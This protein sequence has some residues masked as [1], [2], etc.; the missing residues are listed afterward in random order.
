MLEIRDEN[1]LSG[2]IPPS[3]CAK[4]FNVKWLSGTS[5]GSFYIGDSQVEKE[6]IAK[7]ITGEHK[8]KIDMPSFREYAHKLKQI[9][10]KFKNMFYGPVNIIDKNLSYFNDL[11]ENEQYIII[12]YTP[13]ERYLKT[14]TG[15]HG[16]R[17]FKSSLAPN[18]TNLE[19][20]K[21]TTNEYIVY[22]KIIDNWRDEIMK[23]A[24][25]CDVDSIVTMFN[26]FMSEPNRNR[27]DLARLFGIKYA[28]L[29][30]NNNINA[31]ELVSKSSFNDENIVKSLQNGMLLSK[32]II[33]ETE[34]KYKDEEI[35]DVKYLKFQHLVN[36]FVTQLNINNGIQEGEKH[37]GHGYNGE[38]IREYYKDWRD[39]GCFS[40]DCTISSGYNSS[41][42]KANYI[43]KTGTGIN[44]R[45]TF[46][47]SERKEV[48]DLY[49]D[50]FS[51][52]NCQDNETVNNIC[53][54]HYEISKLGLNDENPNDLLKSLFDD[55][56]TIITLLSNI[57]LKYCLENF[58]SS[59]ERN[60]IIFGAPG[61]GKSYKLN[62]DVNNFAK[63]TFER[64]TFHPDYTYAN[65]V[66]TYKPVP[67]KN[68]PKDITYKY[69][70]GPFMRT[71]VKAL[72]SINDSDIAGECKDK[73]YVLVI[74]EINRANVAAVFGEVFQLLD[75]TSN[76]ESK[77][78]INA[79]EDIKNYLVEELGGQP[80]DF[81]TIKIPN[82][83]F[84]WATM[85]SA[86]QG[87]F[88]VDTAFK[89]RWSFEYI[90]INENDNKISS[91]EITIA[92]K[93]F[94]WNDLRKSINNF[95]AKN[96]VNEDK[97]LGP[98]FIEEKILNDNKKFLETFKDKVIMYLF[99]DAG[100]QLRNS[101]FVSEN[102]S[103]L[104]YSK[105]CENFD[106]D[107]ISIFNNEIQGGIE[108]VESNN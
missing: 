23:R 51:T 27:E 20:K 78:E 68:N 98:F 24:N 85:N 90:G 38:K 17:Q 56:E 93:T 103:P 13:Y 92:N 102:K 70:P 54:K 16:V 26:G 29:L 94:K 47:S 4:N 67:D 15:D 33:W 52:K 57:K 101:I 34:D 65:F 6:K 107:G 64:V 36:W 30:N 66:G 46:S 1:T 9:T 8:C 53:N 74:E 79:S 5:T 73:P 49:I 84:I 32:D 41:S 75:R 106:K 80:E 72:K 81:D 22:V 60:R 44:I 62:E 77:Y 43:N 104:L 71:L 108:N 42:S 48:V 31:N 76:G 61:T 97:L 40:L 14:S 95:L 28:L 87:V 58:D 10:T 12:S 11:L 18:I 63:N 105:I 89:R 50:I 96:R 35:I 83:M 19:I 88:P 7:F 21:T 91:Y 3:D 25:K 82:N 69:V 55:Y 45:P 2:I 37:S 100:R 39:Y 86:D 59:F 99:E